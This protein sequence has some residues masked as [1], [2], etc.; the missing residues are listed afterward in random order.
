MITGEQLFQICPNMKIERA[1]TIADDMRPLL[2][3]YKMD[4]YDILHEFIANIVHESYY[5]R[6][7]EE[8]LNYSAKRLMQVWK[9]HFN[10]S[11]AKEYAFNP[12]KLANKIYGTGSIARSLGNLKPEHGFM[13]RGSGFIQLT[14]YANHKAYGDFVGMSVEDAGKA[15]RESDITAL[16]SSMWFYAVR[17]KLIPVSKGNSI[18]EV[19]KKINGG[20][21][22]MDHRKEIF[23]NA[24]R[25]L[26]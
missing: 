4:F 22:G 8:S 21:I 11:N 25:I 15:M 24:K 23:E 3:F 1:K 10:E 9:N 7:K 6:K 17:A 18:V 16:D 20:T 2:K 26:R 19:S 14:G 13:C 5:F 12:E